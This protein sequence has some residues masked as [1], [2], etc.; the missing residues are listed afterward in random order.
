[1]RRRAVLALAG[2]GTVSLAGCTAVLESIQPDTGR[3]VLARS[4]ETAREPPD[5]TVSRLSSLSLE[6]RTLVRDT[7]AAARN[8]SYGEFQGIKRAEVRT[9]SVFAATEETNIHI[10]ADGSLHRFSVD[11]ADTATT[12]SISYF[13]T[14]AESSGYYRFETLT[15]REQQLFDRVL[16]SDSKS[17]GGPHP[18]EL[19]H[20]TPTGDVTAP[21]SGLFYILKDREIYRLRVF[22]E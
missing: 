5:G 14:W 9:S 12:V 4:S 3:Y 11:P 1:M 22:V 16:G 8:A 21:G 15:D 18:E 7:M 19:V 13:G 2:A 10:R 6:D 17:I 20:F